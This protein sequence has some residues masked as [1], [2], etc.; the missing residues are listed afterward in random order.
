MLIFFLQDVI[1]TNTVPLISR[2]YYILANSKKTRTLEQ[3]EKSVALRQLHRMYP[4]SWYVGWKVR[5]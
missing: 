5:I 3:F 1:K 4:L 2:L